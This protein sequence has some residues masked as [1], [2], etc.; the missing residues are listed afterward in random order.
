MSIGHNSRPNHIDVL[1]AS[2]QDIADT[3][4]LGVVMALVE[5]F[6]GQELNI[7]QKLTP[8]HKLYKLGAANA[9]ALTAFCP[10]DKVLVPV[11]LDRGKRRRQM[12]ALE[13]AG[14]SRG[15]IASELGCSQRHVRRTLNGPHPPDPNQG[16]LFAGFDPD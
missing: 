4:G 15:E 6:P 9:E 13:N 11:T 3:L 14:L 5:H 7:P 8:G 16:D 1:P 12:V 10:Q 2:V